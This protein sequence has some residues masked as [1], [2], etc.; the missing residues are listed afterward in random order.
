[1]THAPSTHAT[2]T[3]ATNHLIAAPEGWWETYDPLVPAW[4]ATLRLRNPR[5]AMAARIAAYI[6]LDAPLLRR[7][8]AH[9]DPARPV[10]SW[11]GLDAEEILSHPDLL[12]LRVDQRA[13]TLRYVG[14]FLDFL[15]S[16]GA[17]PAEVWTNVRKDYDDCVD[18]YRDAL[19][20]T[21]VELE[22]HRVPHRR[23]AKV[24]RNRPCP[25]GSGAKFKRCCARSVH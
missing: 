21:E 8:W 13:R 9:R 5:W 4:E 22:E 25:C 18:R 6:L 11:E 17:V 2:P 20:E 16:C 15:G 19:L 10:D 12:R 3:L 23:A 7:R 1:M 24:G 14:D